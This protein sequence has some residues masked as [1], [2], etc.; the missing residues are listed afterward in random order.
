MYAVYMAGNSHRDAQR[1]DVDEVLPSRRELKATEGDHRRMSRHGN[2]PQ[3]AA[4]SVPRAWDR[5]AG[6]CFT[7]RTPAGIAIASISAN[8]GQSSK[9]R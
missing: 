9:M 8:R 5:T 1:E 6:R 7:I 3:A 4:E 2:R